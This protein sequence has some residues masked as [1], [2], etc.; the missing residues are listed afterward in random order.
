MDFKQAFD[1]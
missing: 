1:S